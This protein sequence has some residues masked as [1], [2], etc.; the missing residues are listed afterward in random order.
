MNRDVVLRMVYQYL[1]EGGHR[2]AAMALNDAV[3]EDLVDAASAMASGTLLSTLDAYT[4]FKSQEPVKEEGEN[5]DDLKVPGDGHF[6]A[7]LCTAITDLHAGNIIAGALTPDALLLTGSADKTIKVLPVGGLP[8]YAL[9]DPSK[10]T[11]LTHHTGPVLALA[12]HPA[13]PHLALSADMVGRVVLFNVAS[14]AVLQ[15]WTA[16]KKYVVRVK[17]SS[18]GKFFASAGYDKTCVLYGCEGDLPAAL[19]GEGGGAKVPEF[20]VLNTFH[21]RGCVESIVFTLTEL[22]IGSREDHLIHLVKLGSLERREIN[23]NALGDTHISF[24]PMDL[25]VSPNG[26]YL[27]VSTDKDRL[28]MYSL[29]TGNVIRTLYGA[30]NDGYSNPKHCW[31]PTGL[32]IYSTSQNFSIVVWETA[33]QKVVAELKGHTSNIRDLFYSPETSTLMSCGFDKTVHV[34]KMLD[35]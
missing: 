17:W 18:C 6:C 31:H 5:T 22:A 15:D 10:A 13:I 4:D 2:V 7:E 32:Y 28:I 25:S 26:R 35:A 3:E 23:M 33:T 20:R 14:G 1:Y 29:E 27:L 9:C 19:E 30:N 8:S 24:T 11:T 21:L 12:V 16:H 34:W